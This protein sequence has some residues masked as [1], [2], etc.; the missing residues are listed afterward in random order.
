MK[1][2]RTREAVE[3]AGVRQNDKFAFFRDNFY[4]IRYDGLL[5]YSFTKTGVVAAQKRYLCLCRSSTSNLESLKLKRMEKVLSETQR[6]CW[7]SL[8]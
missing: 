1:G 7:T 5:N 4:V 2:R 8:E 6:P 3:K